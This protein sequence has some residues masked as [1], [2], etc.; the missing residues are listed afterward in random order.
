M[1][2]C[3]YKNIYIYIY[4]YIYI[5][6]SIYLYTHT[7][8][9]TYI[10]IY[11]HTYTHIYIYIHVHTRTHTYIYIGA[12]TTH[13]YSAILDQLNTNC[14]FHLVFTVHVSWN[15]ARA[16]IVKEINKQVRITLRCFSL[17]LEHFGQSNKIFRP[18][19]FG[20]G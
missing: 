16:I 2:S 15:I 10:Y 14:Y 7:H 1:T 6:I 5:Y 3:Y 11:I 17:N 13:Q 20:L 12:A 4:V 18:I 8:T 9:H 19:T